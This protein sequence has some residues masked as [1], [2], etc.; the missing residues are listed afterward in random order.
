MF[1][2][3]TNYEQLTTDKVAT[4]ILADIN[5]R[6]EL[7]DDMEIIETMPLAAVGGGA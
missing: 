2:L 4:A 5:R 6:M 3:K 7:P 1:D